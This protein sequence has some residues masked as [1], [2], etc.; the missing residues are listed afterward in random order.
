MK[1]GIIGGGLTGLV[2]AHALAQD[3]DI[4]LY[5]KMPYPGGCLSSYH[6][7]DYWIERYY[8]HCFSSDTVLFSLLKELGLIERLEWK[9]GTT[10][11]LA[12]DTIYPLNTPLEILRY[13]ELSFI[14]KARLGWLTLTAK[15]ADLTSLDDLPA[16]QFVI[17]NL[18]INIYTSFFEPL[19][20]SKFGNRRKEVSAA[21]LI[22]R[23]AIRSNRGVEGER[24]GYIR[25][26][27]HNLIDALVSSVNSQGG[28]ICLQ[29][30]VTT[31]SR[32]QKGWTINGNQFDSVIST[33]PPHELERYGGPEL[34][35]IPYQ[36]AACMTLAM[37]RE[38]T[39]GI[40]WL[41]MKDPAPYGA[42]VTHTNFI[43][44]EQ[45]GE[46][47]VYLASY[48]SGSVPPRLDERMLA[49][50]CSRF[51]V[52]PDEITWNRMAVDPFAGPVYTTGYRSLIPRYENKGLFMAG[53]FSKTNYPER[54]MDGSIRA[55][56]E[57][58][59]CLRKQ[60]THEQH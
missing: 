49:N 33:I 55:G 14:D 48:F 8:H 54:S 35:H 58:A 60:E 42:V 34:P 1:I 30:P 37:N 19:L 28:K 45:Y 59:E 57:V 20:K 39:R 41:N 56:F 43:P 29:T 2:A 3:H 13:P 9:T 24:L 22:S 36:G 12:R 21:W 31:V 26:G 40:Y 11:Y 38:V 4:T 5:E 44:V 46:H 16:D 15:T 17:E 23:I 27:F 10:G 25:G 53:M 7:N 18:G 47:L 51:S 52:S 32:V 6:I 50:F